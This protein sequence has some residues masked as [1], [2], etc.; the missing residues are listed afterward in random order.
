METDRLLLRRWREVDRG[1]FGQLNADPRVMEKLG[2]R[3]DPRRDF[4]HPSLPEGYRLRAHAFY[5][6]TQAEWQVREKYSSDP[7]SH[8]PADG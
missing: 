7:K 5:S 6:M 2:L 3:H 4:D 8:S 1:A